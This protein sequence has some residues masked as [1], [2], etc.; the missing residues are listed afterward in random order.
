MID[1]SAY[2]GTIDWE[3]VY[4]SGV[5]Q[6][7]VKATEG[8]AYLDPHRVL[9]AENARKAGLKVGFYHFAHPSNSPV[10]EA[11]H[12][13]RNA[14]HKP[15]DLPPALDLEITEG[16]D[17]PFLNDWKAQ[18]MAVVDAEIGAPHG[19]V[20]YSYFYFLKSMVLYP[21]RPVWGAAYGTFTPPESWAIWQYSPTGR[22]PGV[23][24]H[25]DLD[26]QLKPLTLLV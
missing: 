15:G 21:D 22:V 19:T 17:W 7:Y 10:E 13:V 6:A 12:F 11:T 8:T 1:V 23:A 3:A 26:K 5:K 4:D 9:N 14:P 24:G 25:V 20:F 2:Q 16:H 18:F